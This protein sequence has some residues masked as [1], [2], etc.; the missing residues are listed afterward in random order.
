MNSENLW[1]HMNSSCY[2]QTR[3]HENW[4]H[5]VTF[6]Y[7]FINYEF[8]YEF[9]NYEFIYEC[10][11]ISSCSVDLQKNSHINTY[12]MNSYFMNS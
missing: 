6:I 9:I 8:I 10:D 12:I 3:I 7:E 4:I 11:A 5:N 1:I 2:I